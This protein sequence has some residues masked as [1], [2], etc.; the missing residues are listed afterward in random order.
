MNR[1]LAGP[2]DMAMSALEG[3][4][5]DMA[6]VDLEYIGQVLMGTFT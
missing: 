1:P 3:G 5:E 4:S 2:L 6:G